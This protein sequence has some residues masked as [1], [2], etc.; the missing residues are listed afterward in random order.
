MTIQRIIDLP[1]KIKYCTFGT[2]VLCTLLL[3]FYFFDFQ[4]SDYLI[5]LRDWISIIQQNGGLSALAEPFYNYS[6]MYMYFLV[7]IAKLEQWFD[8]N[9]LYTIKILSIFFE[10]ILAYFIGKIA[11]QY[12][13]NNIYIWLSIL[14]VPLIPAVI[15]DSSV[16]SQCD[17]IYSTFV[18]ASIYCLLERKSFASILLFGIAF[19]FKAQATFVLPFFFVYMLRGHIKWYYFLSVPVV[20]FISIIPT[21]MVGRSLTDL[22]SIYA[23][24]STYN[25]GLVTNLPN[26]YLW[27]QDYV[28]SNKTIYM[29]LYGLFI[30]LSGVILM[31]KKY[32]YTLSSW[33][34][35]IFLSTL[36]SPYFLPGMLDRYLYLADVFVVIYVFLNWRN[37]PI[38]ILVWYLSAT[39]RAKSILGF[40]LSPLGKANWDYYI[41]FEDLSKSP[42]MVNGLLFILVILYVTYDF[43]KELK[44]NTESEF[45]EESNFKI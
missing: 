31:K 44:Q 13:K 27:I 36:V 3:K 29:L 2:I 17:A 23:A 40:A 24:Q 6:P 35:L 8:I 11:S 28:S 4:Y 18:I 45:V 25:S 21:W 19:S 30:F 33:F 22:L 42:M 26:I 1:L 37:F 15:L 10:Y 20:Y 32:T 16:M 43:L 9:T 12:F 14:V 39:C 34:K 7:V 41:L 38:A 5:F